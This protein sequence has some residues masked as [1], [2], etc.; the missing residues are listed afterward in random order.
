MCAGPAKIEAWDIFG[1]IVGP[2][3]GALGQE[4]FKLKSGTLKGI[5]AGFEIARSEDQLADEVFSQIRNNC[6][7]QCGQDAVC[8]S[9]LLLVPIDLVSG[10]TEVRNGREDIKAFVSLGG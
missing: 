9:F 5:E 10:R 1:D 2:E 4:G 8:I 3:P 6:F 7:L